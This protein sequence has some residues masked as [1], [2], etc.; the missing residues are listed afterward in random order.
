MSK[1]KYKI[2]LGFTYKGKDGKA[3]QEEWVRIGP[4]EEVP[5][6]N[7]DELEILIRQEKIAEISS[8]TGS[9]IQTKKVTVLN[10]TEIERFMGKS[11]PSILAAIS[12][13]ELSIE[14]LGKM[15]VI[16]ER[17]KMDARIKNT[18]EEKINAKV[19]A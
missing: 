5:E 13:E 12:S 16:A 11:A 6:L 19:S 9:I 14:T 1:K 7:S 4:G 18:I 3:K 17:Q 10:D 2:I 15:L 8:E